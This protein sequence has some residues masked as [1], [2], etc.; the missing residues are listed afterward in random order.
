MTEATA[1]CGGLAI[2]SN[3]SKSLI[4]GG[5]S[6]IMKVVFESAKI[7]KIFQFFPIL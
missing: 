4:I 2:A 3:N 7:Q 6:I 1:S 5:L